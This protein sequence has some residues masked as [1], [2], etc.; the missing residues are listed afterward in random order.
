[1]FGRPVVSLRR[2]LEPVEARRTTDHVLGRVGGTNL[3]RRLVAADRRWWCLAEH[4][5]RAAGRVVEGLLEPVGARIVR[6]A[7]GVRTPG[8]EAVSL[9]CRI[10]WRRGLGFKV[11]L[12]HGEQVLVVLHFGRKTS[13]HKGHTF[14]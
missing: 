11:P 9:S 12:D 5:L 10:R 2:L 14:G 13:Q 1:L 4:A 3:R 8:G 7:A 6:V